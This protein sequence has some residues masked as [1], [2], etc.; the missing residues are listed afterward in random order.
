MQAEDEVDCCEGWVERGQLSTDIQSVIHI[1]VFTLRPHHLSAGESGDLSKE[2]LPAQIFC[3]QGESEVA[4]AKR[5]RAG[6]LPGW[7]TSFG[8][9]QPVGRW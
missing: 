6:L 2:L 7:I 8:L 1:G 9:P 4:E 5:M 3:V